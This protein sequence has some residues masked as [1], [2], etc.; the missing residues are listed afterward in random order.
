MIRV[1]TKGPICCCKIF[2][3]ASVLDQAKHEGDA[4]GKLLQVPLQE[5]FQELVPVALVKHIFHYSL[6]GLVSHKA[7]PRILRRYSWSG[8]LKCSR[9]TSFRAQNSLPASRVRI[10]S[11]T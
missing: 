11:L 9:I 6:D 4:G 3:E 10:V 2:L 8:R 7:K 5:A 1:E